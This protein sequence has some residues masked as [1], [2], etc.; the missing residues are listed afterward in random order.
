VCEVLDGLAPSEAIE[1]T[2]SGQYPSMQMAEMGGG[3]EGGAAG[4]GGASG[5]HPAAYA[6]R[7]TSVGVPPVTTAPIDKSLVEAV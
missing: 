2:K 4:G 7:V 5:A 1:S 3:D 6:V